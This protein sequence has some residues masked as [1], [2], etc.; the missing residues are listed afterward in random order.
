MRKAKDSH[1]DI[2]SKMNK[3][4]VIA[5][6]AIMAASCGEPATNSTASNTQ[7]KTA[8]NGDRGNEIIAE[9][10]KRDAAP[11]R[12]TRVRFNIT[13][14]DGVKV[15]EIDVWRKQA[16]DETSTLTQIIKPE[17]DSDLASL[18]LE[19]KDKP[20]NVTSYSTT[21]KDFRETDTNK[22]FFGGITAGELLGE[23]HKF[24]FRLVKEEGGQF[25]LEGRL[26]KGES[27]TVARSEVTMSSDNYVPKQ[28]KL[29]DSS[30]KLIRT[31]DIT[32]TKT[33]DHGAYASKTTVDNPIYK[34]KTEIE[35][36]SREF[37]A[38]VDPT[39]FTKD[40]LKAI[41]SR[42]K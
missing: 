42:S 31:F 41:A 29:Y 9:F 34:T 2:F 15:Y 22:M 24:D 4:L 7:K 16:G 28:L 33:D 27:G 11:L 38:T 23:W 5:M 32:D 20:A 36:L 35:I 30:D 1:I 39:F 3:F 19:T 18:T 13:S 14:E 12:K 26:K 17:E 21:L 6:L 10:L 25:Q 40:K 8:G 37:P